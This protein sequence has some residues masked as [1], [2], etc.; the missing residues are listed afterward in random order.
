MKTIGAAVFL[1]VSASSW[2]STANFEFPALKYSDREPGSLARS[3][4][5]KAIPNPLPA[6][7]EQPA[8]KPARRHFDER[9]G[10]ITPPSDADYKLRIIAANPKIDPGI[11]K[12]ADIQ[13]KTRPKQ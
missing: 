9:S 6:V 12:G 1:L 10:I 8:A 13:P 2:A 5:Q 11:I 3:P 4:L 7:A